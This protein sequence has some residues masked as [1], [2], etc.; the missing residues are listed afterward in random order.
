MSFGKCRTFMR[1]LSIVT[2]AAAL[3][4]FAAAPAWTVSTDGQSAI[5]KQ[6]AQP[7]DSAARIAQPLQSPR[8]RHLGPHEIPTGPPPPPRWSRPPTKPAPAIPPKG[9]QP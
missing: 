6:N 1:Q 8:G 3:T 7:M 4:I 5:E 2:V 9:W